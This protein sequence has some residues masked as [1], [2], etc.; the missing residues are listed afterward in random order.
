MSIELSELDQMQHGYKTAVDEWVTAIRAEE[1]LASVDHSVAEVD[2]W[3]QAGFSEEA[4]R[5]K[6]KIAKKKY[7]AALRL[8]FFDFS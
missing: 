3:E 8:K 2:L 5:A 6:V 4:F 7:E 1:A